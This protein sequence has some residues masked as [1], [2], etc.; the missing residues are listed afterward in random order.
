MYIYACNSH[1]S[2]CGSRGIAPLI[3]S[4]GPRWRLS[5]QFEAPTALLLGTESAV[6]TD[7]Q[8]QL[9]KA[10]IDCNG[11]FKTFLKGYNVELRISDKLM[12]RLGLTQKWEVLH[13]P[14]LLSTDIL[15]LMYR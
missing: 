6:L 7:K 1:E 5:D 15:L 10:Y 3:L 8:S 12:C 13:F 2:V 11:N 4:L 14:I 9:Y